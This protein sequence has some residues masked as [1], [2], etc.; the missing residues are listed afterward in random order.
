MMMITK[1]SLLQSVYEPHS[2]AIALTDQYIDKTSGPD[3]PWVFD[4]LVLNGTYAGSKT[5]TLTVNWLL[6]TK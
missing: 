4:A 1:G 2:L 6:I 5:T 3:R